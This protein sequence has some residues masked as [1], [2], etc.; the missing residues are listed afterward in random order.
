M[1]KK[2]TKKTTAKKAV[3]V[4][5]KKTSAKKTTAKKSAAKPATKKATVKKTT[6]KSAAKKKTSAKKTTVKETVSKKQANKTTTGTYPDLINTR[7]EQIRFRFQEL[8]TDGLVVNYLPNIRYLTNFSGSN[9]MLIIFNEEI[10]FFT[11]DRYEEQIK[12]EL[13]SL[14][15]LKTFI[16]RDVWKYCNEKKLLKNIKM[17]AFEGDRVAYSEAVSTRNKIRPLKFKP[18][19]DKEVERYTM[20]KAPE[21]LANIEEACRL[22]EATYKKILKFIKPGVTEKDIANEIAYIS[23]KLGSEKDPFDIIVASGPRGAIVHG[24]PTDKKIKVGDVIIMDFGCTY[25]GFVSDITRTVAIG[26]AT[27]EQKEIYKLLVHAKDTA[28]KEVHPL[29]NGIHL[30]LV[31]R[32]IIKK[33]GYGDYFK[34]SLGHGVGLVVHES[35]IINFQYEGQI[36]P[37]DIVLAIEP[38]IYLPGKFGMRVEDDIF[39][40]REGA[41]YLTKAP[42]ELPII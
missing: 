39:V 37:E 19:E 28:I 22:A 15:G 4:T 41:R 27:K 33:A 42:E 9:A 36:I 38:G 17:L 12:T 23:R 32:D 20:P 1:A 3:K 34:H 6:A 13:Y 31:A 8:K 18:A 29:M 2:T 10:F 24:T 30:D 14:P 26:K 16:T 21:E 35:P 25:N 7:L 11:D 5:S 40:A